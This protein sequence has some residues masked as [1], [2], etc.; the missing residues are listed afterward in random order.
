MNHLPNNINDSGFFPLE[1]SRLLNF[2]DVLRLQLSGNDVIRFF[3][4]LKNL[5][6]TIGSKQALH[7][8]TEEISIFPFPLR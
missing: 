5:T 4:F 7:S 1:S 2:R 3:K 8:G 6:Q